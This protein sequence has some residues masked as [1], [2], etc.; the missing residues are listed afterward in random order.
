MDRLS[1]AQ[2]LVTFQGSQLLGVLVAL[3]VML[4]VVQS[5]ALFFGA[6]LGRQITS[7]VHELFVGTERVQ[8]GDFTHRI[9]IESTDQ[10]GA[11]SDSFNRMSASMEHLLHVQREKQRLDDEL[12]IA[13]DI[14][15]SLLPEAPP[16]FA[17][18][19]IADLC[20]PAREV[21][22]DYYDFFE[23]GP[24]EFGALVAH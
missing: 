5:V 14:Q 18:L 7:A 13:R 11:L 8:Q 21:G 20:V 9:P 17:G 24:R 4:L 10:L 1:E 15:Q 3:G 16:V 23:L 22:G 6:G 12:R 19:T 2:G